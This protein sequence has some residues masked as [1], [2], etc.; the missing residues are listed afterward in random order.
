MNEKL[1]NE[2]DKQIEKRFEELDWLLS[3]SCSDNNFQGY[4]MLVEQWIEF[5]KM[6][7]PV[8]MVNYYGTTQ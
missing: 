7:N 5:V 6:I 2:I 3:Q 1:K 8:E 4:A